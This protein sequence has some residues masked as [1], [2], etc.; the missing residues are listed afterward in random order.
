ML[1]YSQKRRYYFFIA[2]AKFKTILSYYPPLA[3]AFP[4]LLILRSTFAQPSLM[5]APHLRHTCATL[6]PHTL[7]NFQSL[8]KLISCLAG[9]SF[10]PLLLILRHIL[11]CASSP[12]FLR[13]ILGCASSPTFLRSSFAHRSLIVRSSFAH[14]SVEENVY[15]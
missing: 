15:S 10:S 14:R 2:I 3:Q 4:P 11:G 6:A 8:P 13:H 9:A 1:H 12:T 7:A 5:I